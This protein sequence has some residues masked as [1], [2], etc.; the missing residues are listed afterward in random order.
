MADIK[1]VRM[2]L[3]V[4]IASGLGFA[5]AMTLAGMGTNLFEL[6]QGIGLLIAAAC[7]YAVSGLLE[8]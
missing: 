6:L 8:E 3:F 1:K 4:I 5:G 2:I 7:T